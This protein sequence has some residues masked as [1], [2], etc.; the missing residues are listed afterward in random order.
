MSQRIERILF[1]VVI[2]FLL[3]FL[4]H[5][6]PE[7]PP[8]PDDIVRV[9]TF[10]V[11]VPAKRDT[12]KAGRDTARYKKKNNP[13]NPPPSNGGLADCCLD[14]QLLMEDTAEYNYFLKDSNID[15]TVTARTVA[16]AVDSFYSV[17]SFRNRIIEIER[18]KFVPHYTPI[19]GYS[20]YPY[21]QA[22]LGIKNS[23]GA[24]AFYLKNRSALGAGYNFTNKQVVLKYGYGIF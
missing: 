1:V 12:A 5:R 14:Y 11:E 6:R 20:L 8:V 24:G 2:A 3:Y 10:Y 17:Y 19:K 18:T 22:D 16:G 4:I 23:Y 15:L 7:C 21:I 9:D 13:I